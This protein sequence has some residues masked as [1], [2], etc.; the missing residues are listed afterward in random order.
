MKI[1][2]CKTSLDTKESRAI[3]KVLKSGW[4]TDG[5]MNK[6]FEEAFAKYI[7]VKRALTLNSCTTA[8]QLAI[9]ASNITGEVI[10]PSFTFVASA[11]AVVRGGATPVFAD[12]EYDSCNIDPE[13]IE[14]KITPR[15]QAIMVVHFAGQSC[16]MDK[17]IKLAAKHKLKI[18]E[19]SA[20][21]IGATYNNQKTGSFSTGCFS[22]FPTKNLT[23]GEGGMLTTNNESFA[24]KIKTL[25]AHGIA[26]KTTG[27]Q[28]EADPWH[29]EAAYAGYNFRMS[30]ILA[31]LGVEQLKKLDR[32]NRQ[33]REHAA[34]LNKKLNFDEID[35]PVELKGCRHVYQMYTIKIKRIPRRDFVLG[36]RKMGIMASV[37]FT[38]PVHLQ[39]YYAN[40][41]KY[42]L[43][44]LPVTKRVTDSIVTLPMYP[45][46]VKKE[47][48]Y[49]V[50]S[51]TK[52]LHKLNR[53]QI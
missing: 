16:R 27:C 31:A 4:L 8:L 21:A 24:D 3:A 33:R 11:N 13:D 10:L 39:E 28:P 2:L 49:I 42:S 51:V 17:I 48:D 6:R 12:I 52:I 41:Y 30:S 53:R 7:G 34:Y 44:D 1:P 22:F 19:D 35:L 46:L 37:H 23:T 15:T 5:P 25:A 18:I 47:L 45:G 9:E 50:N 26:K 36:L 32:M 29:R 14:R 38:P 40:K 20:E 43:N